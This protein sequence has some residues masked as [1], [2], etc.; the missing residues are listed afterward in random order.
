M[1]ENSCYQSVTYIRVCQKFWKVN[2]LN[3][4]RFTHFMHPEILFVV[5]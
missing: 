1:G 5:Y 3:N 4:G 2:I